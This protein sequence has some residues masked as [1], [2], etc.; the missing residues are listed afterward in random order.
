MKWDIENKML[1]PFMILVILPIL[2][3]GIVSY[4]NGYQLL[5]NNKTKNIE[6]NLND[7]MVFI[8]RIDEE[9]EDDE[10][11]KKK[12]IDYFT[13]LNKSGMVISQNNRLIINNLS[14]DSS[15]VEGILKE[16]LGAKEAV[17]SNDDLLFVYR[18]FDE[19][20]W[21]IGYGLNKDIFTDELIEIQK[22]TLLL[23]I[24]FLIFSMQATILISHNISKPMKMLAD[25][26]HR[27]GKGNLNEKIDINREDEIGI[28]ADAFNNM[29]RKLEKNRRK[30]LYMKKYS[31]DIL[32]NISVGIITTDKKGKV[33]SI[34][35]AG[36]NILEYSMNSYE[37][38]EKVHSTLMRQLSD[39]LSN[40]ESRN[41]IIVFNRAADGSKQYL[42][43]TTSL[44]R[45]EN[46]KTSGAICSFSDIT[47]RKRIENNIERIN[48]LTS[49]GELAAGLAHEIRNPL[50]GMK[51]SIQVLKGR[52][53]TDNDESNL[54]LFDSTI[55]E[56]DRLN[57]LIT[58]LL[59]FARPHSPKCEMTNMLE[60]LDMSLDLTKKDMKEKD[61]KTNV[62]IETSNLLVF[63][64]KA[65]IEQ[66]FINIIKNA[67]KASK[68]H[69]KLDIRLK[70]LSNEKE[71]LLYISF[72][73]NGEGIKQENLE[74]IFNPFFT[75]DPQ[76]TGLGLSV[77]HKLVIEN[78]GEIE[79]QSILEKGTKFEI[80]F[81]INGG[82]IDE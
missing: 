71:K 53:C 81:P 50:A 40:K 64:D 7:H 33:I 1:I 43:V 10:L 66:V 28:L 12:V 36:K 67:V 60:I 29:V 56:I 54:R 82:E 27:I 21:T 73:D 58:E 49:V 37:E 8:N 55:Y 4:W 14:K 11:A 61:I 76:G 79:V 23:A 52:L 47:R 19:W 70:A 5:L 15:F 63:V 74:K 13:E 46:E 3:L 80:K 6:D 45:T 16:A 77:V 30:L 72:E 62:H 2:I 17:Y 51:M 75:T 9:I 35:Q 44:L 32:K 78:K 41:D 38:K 25:M 39:T 69:G 48:R 24:I 31:E 26:C 57:S 22:Y 18:S 42:D 59:D 34:N 20:Q 68:Q 65:Q